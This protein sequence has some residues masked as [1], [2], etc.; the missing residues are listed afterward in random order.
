MCDTVIHK[1]TFCSDKCRVAYHREVNAL[2]D[3]TPTLSESYNRTSKI[4]PKRK[5]VTVKTQ[6]ETFK[7]PNSGFKVCE[8]HGAQISPMMLCK[9]GC[10]R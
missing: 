8:K 3:G 7:V 10:K 1:R 9:F 2:L 6:K 5:E 4:L